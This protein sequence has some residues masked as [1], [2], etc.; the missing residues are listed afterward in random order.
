M[1]AGLWR[2]F[3]AVAE[4]AYG[5]G[6]PKPPLIFVDGIAP[7]AESG[8]NNLREQVLSLA[9]DQRAFGPRK[10]WTAFADA[11]GR[12]GGIAYT[13]R[14]D[15][16]LI[17]FEACL[18][19]QCDRM[20][21]DAAAAVVFC[22]EMIANEPPSNASLERFRNARALAAYFG[23]HLV[24]WFACDDEIFLAARLHTLRVEEQPDWWDL[25]APP[26]SR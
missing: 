7:T 3:S 6:M 1:N 5:A 22:D 2:T 19:Y 17:A 24:D 8:L 25:P 20:G 23:V 26:G 11:D 13:D 16:P 14:T 12:L 9:L 15:P 18:H 10:L 4:H 21:T